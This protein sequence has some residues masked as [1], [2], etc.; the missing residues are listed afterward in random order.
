MT[1][2]WQFFLQSAYWPWFWGIIGLLIGSFLNVVIIR[3]PARLDWGWKL[4]CHV[5]QGGNEEEFRE[6]N[7][8]PADLVFAKSRCPHCG[9][10]IRPWENVPVFGYLWLRGKCAGCKASFSAQYPL[11]EALTGIL[12]FIVASLTRDPVV[13]IAMMTFMSMLIACS[14]ID[15]KTK[16]LPDVIVYPLLWIG[17]LASAVGVAGFPSPQDAIIGAIAGYMTL[18]TVYWVFKLVTKREG[19]GFGD[20]KLLAAIGA[21]LGWIQLPW[22]LLIST[23]VGVVVGVVALA[24]QGNGYRIAIPF[25]PFLAVAAAFSWIFTQLGWLPALAG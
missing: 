18:W 21:W 22:V 23:I 25:G 4:D 1:S 7:P 2:T 12:F 17:L 11:I 6:A 5:F 10:S 24:K 16:I 3:L 19:M 14:G 9:H 15:A 20:F 13:A 8:P